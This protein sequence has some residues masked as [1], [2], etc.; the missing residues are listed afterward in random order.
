[1]D[2]KGDFRRSVSA[3]VEEE[4]IIMKRHG[5]HLVNHVVAEGNEFA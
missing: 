5:R 4:G 2:F 3:A 1:M